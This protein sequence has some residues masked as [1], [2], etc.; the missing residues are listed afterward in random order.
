M[1]KKQKDIIG[2]IKLYFFYHNFF[3]LF[4]RKEIT[5]YGFRN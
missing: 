1:K 5:D 2:V 3:S 4:D